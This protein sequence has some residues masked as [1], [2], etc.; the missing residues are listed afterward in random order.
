M[1]KVHTAASAKNLLYIISEDGDCIPEWDGIICWPRSTAGELVS[2]QCPEYIYDFNHRG[3]RAPDILASDHL[4]TTLHHTP[5][6]TISC[7]HADQGEPT[8]SVMLQA[9]GSWWRVSTALGQTTASAPD[10]SPSTT[11][12]TRRCVHLHLS[13]GLCR[14]CVI[15]WLVQ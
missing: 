2:V 6:L 9:T 14:L 10:T 12:A 13:G 5:L 1:T 7:P 8:A 4:H 3:T 11:E 15:W